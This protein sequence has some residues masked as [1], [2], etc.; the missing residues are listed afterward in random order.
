MLSRKRA[1]MKPCCPQRLTN[2]L[3]AGFHARDG[4]KASKQI[5]PCRGAEVRAGEDT[6]VGADGEFPGGSH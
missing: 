3:S 1:S 6:A 5:L 4:K 2:F